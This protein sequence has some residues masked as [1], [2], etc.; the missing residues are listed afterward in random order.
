MGIATA[1]P[2]SRQLANLL[3]DEI[4]SGA[5]SSGSRM[6]SVMAASRRF[7]VKPATVYAAYKILEYEGLVVKRVGSGTFVREKVQK[8]LGLVTAHSGDQIYDYFNALNHVLPERGCLCMPVTHVMR[9]GPWKPN[10]EMLKRINP[11]AFMVDVGPFQFDDITQV[12][13]VIGG[14]RIC[15]VHRWDWGGIPPGPAVLVDML[16]FYRKSF[17]LLAA[18]GHRRILVLGSPHDMPRWIRFPVNKA[19]DGL[20]RL[21]DGVRIDYATRHDFQ[22]DPD[23]IDSYFRDNNPPT[24]IVRN[25]DFQAW[26][27]LHQLTNRYPDIEMPD[28]CVLYG[29]KFVH[30]ICP[31]VNTF[32]VD[33]RRIWEKAVDICLGPDASEKSVEYIEPVLSKTGE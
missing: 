18:K 33:F 12:L 25:A 29:D 6:L 2:K 17:E 9:G 24:A 15:F 22:K 7:S 1:L 21:M 23:R 5:I 10:V 4:M 11:A 19:R 8:T 16:A 3:R 32:V 13:D 28:V 30:T 14:R 26:S 27:F 20:G 31:R